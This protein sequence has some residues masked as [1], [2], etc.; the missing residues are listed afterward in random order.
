VIVLPAVPALQLERGGR[1]V[2]KELFGGEER[3]TAI[4][5]HFCES[6][7]TVSERRK[8]K[9]RKETHC[10]QYRCGLRP[11]QQRRRRSRISYSL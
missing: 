8:R 5:G 10:G 9:G 6:R 1:T 11:F 2:E 3:Q 4:H 7:G